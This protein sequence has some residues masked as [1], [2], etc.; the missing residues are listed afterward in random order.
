MTSTDVVCA[1]CGGHVNPSDQ[2]TL[3]SESTGRYFHHVCP[4][5]PA[6]AGQ[7]DLAGQLVPEEVLVEQPASSQDAAE[8]LRHNTIEMAIESI[9]HPE[10]VSVTSE[11]VKAAAAGPVRIRSAGQ[12]ED[13][14]RIRS[15]GQLEDRERI[16][17]AGG[18]RKPSYRVHC[19]TCQQDI[20]EP[21]DRRTAKRFMN[22]HKT[23]Q[24][25]DAVLVQEGWKW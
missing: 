2:Y 10:L 22:E 25:H 7:V 9:G 21:T 13:R 14:E 11:E 3:H 4:P 15:A 23:N 20:C 8:M 1:K 19:R 17:T 12:L 6:A 16:R 5:A 18:L 24:H